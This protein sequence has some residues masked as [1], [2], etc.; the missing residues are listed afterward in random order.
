MIH[1]CLKLNANFM[2]IVQSLVTI[3][4]IYAIFYYKVQ[5]CKN[6]SLNKLNE[7]IYSLQLGVVGNSFDSFWF[8]E[9]Y[10][11]ISDTILDHFNS[12][13]TSNSLL[14]Q[15]NCLSYGVVLKIMF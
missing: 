10:A 9:L 15:I 5:P 6:L 4:K 8:K 1:A 2:S 3:F 13:K 12:F 11:F 14:I 7:I